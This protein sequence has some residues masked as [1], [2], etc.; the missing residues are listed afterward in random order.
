MSKRKNERILGR[1]Y[2][3][4]EKAA[5]LPWHRA[6]P[7]A[8]LVKALE[9]RAAPGR[10]LD[11][12]C[13]AGTYTLYMARRGYAVTGVDMMPQAIA[14]LRRG[15]G[16]SGL[17]VN[18]VQADILTWSD[19]QPFDVIL[20][21]GCLHSLAADLRP[22]YRQQLLRWLAPGGD[23]IL[24]HCGRR[25]WWDGWPVGPSRVSRNDVIALFAPEL[26]LHDYVEEEL[27][28]LPLFLGRSALTGRYWF[29]RRLSG[30]GS[31]NG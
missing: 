22:T 31:R 20:D 15:A 7:P 30:D 24:I 11:V 29:R 1:L 28:D 8:L 19:D 18:A 2:K 12:G 14:M 4:A 17:E 26:E 5:D 27:R 25:G 23:F 9:Q 6:E 13:G 16:E 10:A 21:V 3:S